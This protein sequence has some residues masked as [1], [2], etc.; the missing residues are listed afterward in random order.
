MVV[1]I[2]WINKNT[3]FIKSEFMKAIEEGVHDILL[4]FEKD[5][6]KPTA[7]FNPPPTF[8]VGKGSITTTDKKFL[9][10]EFGTRVRR[11]TMSRN[12]ISKTTPGSLR[13][14]AGR[15][16]P[17]G[18]GFHTGIKARDWGTASALRQIKTGYLPRA[19]TR[20]MVTRSRLIFR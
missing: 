18:Y 9:W 20:R 8:T 16:K 17:E 12:W 6:K 5:Y 3:R 11:R 7:G 2:K 10:L 14:R 15:G 19:I 1:S 13:S 4:E